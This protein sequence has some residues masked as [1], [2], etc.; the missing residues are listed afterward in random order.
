MNVNATLTL[1]K[2]NAQYRESLFFHT[3]ELMCVSA[4]KNPAKRFTLIQKRIH[5]KK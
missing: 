4:K 5:Q 3:R 2:S 1:C